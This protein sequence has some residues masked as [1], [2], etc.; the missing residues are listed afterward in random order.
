MCR[1]A[2]TIKTDWSVGNRRDDWFRLL[3]IGCCHCWIGCGR[4]SL[5]HYCAAMISSCIDQL[6]SNVVALG[7]LCCFLLTNLMYCVWC[8]GWS[9][10]QNW[11]H[12]RWTDIITHT[13]SFLLWPWF[14]ASSLP[15]CSFQKD[16]HVGYKHWKLYY[17][18]NS[19]LVNL[20]KILNCIRP[21]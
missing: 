2:I 19:T 1:S 5:S 4:L 11:L 16:E 10:R 21:Q 15:S 20:R 12:L 7:S 3:F 9:R 17:L 18:F 8:A 13:L 14:A 6:S